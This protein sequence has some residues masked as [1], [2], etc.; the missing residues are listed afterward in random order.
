MYEEVGSSI[1]F[2]KPPTFTT[3]VISLKRFMT[4]SFYLHMYM[5]ICLDYNCNI[6]LI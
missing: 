4:N 5:F 2:D 1:Q 6:I 3:F